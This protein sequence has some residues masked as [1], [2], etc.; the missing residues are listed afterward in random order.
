M[1]DKIKLIILESIKELK[2]ERPLFH[3]EA[4]F[5]HALA[6]K[7][8]EKDPRAEIRL[9]KRV[10]SKD[11]DKNYVDLVIIKENYEIFIELKYKT[12]LPKGKENIISKGEVFLLANQGA[13][14]LG[15]HNFFIDIHDLERIKCQEGIKKISFAIFLTN[16][17][18]YWT[19]KNPESETIFDQFYIEEG[20]EIK[21]G[22]YKLHST[23][24]N[25]KL[26]KRWRNLGSENN[27]E[28]IEILN[29]YGPLRWDHYSNEA[30]EFKFLLIEIKC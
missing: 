20:R 3:S 15:M 7:I 27:Y 10:K 19:P 29:D 9:E 22:E 25:K 5:Q 12:I 18:Y 2:V 30:D 17:K 16:D 28:K 1:K 11:K 6:V 13:Q 26:I 24:R 8:K 23:K 21:K 4:D 14:D